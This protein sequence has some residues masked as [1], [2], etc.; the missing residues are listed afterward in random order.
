[1]GYYCFDGSEINFRGGG[2]GLVTIAGSIGASGS[3]IAITNLRFGDDVSFRVI[4]VQVSR[5]YAGHDS[6]SA[7]SVGYQHLYGR[8]IAIFWHVRLGSTTAL[9]ALRVR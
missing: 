2:N 5:R 4:L 3:N 7:D 9:G 1:M 6:N 8:S